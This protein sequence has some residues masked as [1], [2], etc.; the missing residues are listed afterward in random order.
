MKQDLIPQQ[1]VQTHAVAAQPVYA[2][3]AA[4]P[5]TPAGPGGV[6]GAGDLCG[7]FDEFESCCLGLFCP[8]ILFGRTV[9]RSRLGG[10]VGGCCMYFFL[11]I[12]V[13]YGITAGG[14]ALTVYGP[15]KDLLSSAVAMGKCP[16]LPEC[17]SDYTPLPTNPGFEQL[18]DALNSTSLAKANC[19]LPAGV[20]VCDCLKAPLVKN[21][22]AELAL[23]ANCLGM[24]V[25]LTVKLGCGKATKRYEYFSYGAGFIQLLICGLFCGHYRAKIAAALG[26][27]SD[28]GYMNFIW[29]FLPCTHACALCAESRAVDRKMR[30]PVAYVPF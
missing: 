18:I 19:V 6:M 23:G 30:G 24:T 26:L 14:G 27:T 7:C 8:C 13:F 16:K 5:V 1:G 17:A 22:K 2:R 28:S 11:I 21:C 9:E 12:I 15:Y 25:D 20:P 10:C 4:Q 3:V 29:H